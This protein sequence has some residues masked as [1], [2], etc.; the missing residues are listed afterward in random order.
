MRPQRLRSLLAASR[1]N[2]IVTPRNQSTLVRAVPLY[3]RTIRLLAARPLRPSVIPT[4]T[5]LASSTAPAAYST[6][7]MSKFHELKAELPNGQTFDFEQ[8]KGKVVL[9]VNTASKW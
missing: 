3:K 1:T 2:N 4:T 6:S 9:I 7:A 5:F 8:L